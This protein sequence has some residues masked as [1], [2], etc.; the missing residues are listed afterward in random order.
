MPIRYEIERIQRVIRT[1][2][3]GYV[4]LSEVIDHFRQLEHDPDC[5]KQLDVV[6]DLSTTTSLPSSDQLRAVGKEIG[7][8]RDRVRFGDCAIVVSS[9]AVFA[10][11]AEFGVHAA[12]A[13][14]ALK[15]FRR[16]DEAE[17]WLAGHP[18]SP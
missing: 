7:R 4:V 3:T 6:L 15:I 11:A 1:R 10:V 9:D 12:K 5:S 13:F 16:L 18:S 14:R 8:I 17:V 2:C